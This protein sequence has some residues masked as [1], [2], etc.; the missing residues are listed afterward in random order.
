[1]MEG[2]R[3][4]GRQWKKVNCETHTE[5]DEQLCAKMACMGKKSQN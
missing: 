4:E 5:S 2:A 3:E 1:M